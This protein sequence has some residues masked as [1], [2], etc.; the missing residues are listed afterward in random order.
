M[1]PNLTP[2]TAV[3]LADQLVELNARIEQLTEQRDALKAQLATLGDGAH[4]AGQYKVT[5]TT[6]RRLDAKRVEKAFPVMDYPQ[7]YAPKLQP[8]VLRRAIGE[9]E[10]EDHDCFTTG[11]PLVKIS[12]A[13]GEDK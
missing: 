4:T 6:P 7:F 13:K 2:D 3:R 12:Q 9:Q 11:A 10:L 8:T 1:N 5:I